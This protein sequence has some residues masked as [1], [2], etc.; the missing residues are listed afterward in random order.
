MLT[1]FTTQGE[2]VKTAWAKT[3]SGL[4]PDLFDIQ[5]PTCK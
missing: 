4:I 5:L 1:Q 3:S 2:F